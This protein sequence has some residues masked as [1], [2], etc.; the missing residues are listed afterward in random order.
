MAM[1]M[2]VQSPSSTS[3][4]TKPRHSL[5]APRNRSRVYTLYQALLT[6]K[7][8]S[9]LET[10]LIQPRKQTSKMIWLRYPGQLRIQQEQSF[11][12]KDGRLN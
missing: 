11:S 10:F 3:L 9:T 12:R 5:P 4:N 2:I 6:Q 1:G 8:G 7:S